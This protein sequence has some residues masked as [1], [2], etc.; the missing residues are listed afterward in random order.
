MVCQEKKISNKT[1][2]GYGSAANNKPKCVSTAKTINFEGDIKDLTLVR[3]QDGK[4]S[5][6]RERFLVSNE[7]PPSWKPIEIF[8]A[9]V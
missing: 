3:R 4:L 9:G 1:I 2:K 6:T 8:P 5:H 7:G